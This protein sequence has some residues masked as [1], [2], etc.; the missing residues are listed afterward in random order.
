MKQ[1]IPSPDGIEKWAEWLDSMPKRT[2]LTEEQCR[3]FMAMT[4]MEDYIETDAEAL[5][6]VE[7]KQMNYASMFYNRVKSCHT[8]KVSVAVA[9]FISSLVDRPGLV[10]IYANYLQYK[11]F[12]FGKKKLGMQDMA[13]IMPFGVFSKETL[14]QAWDKQKWYGS[15]GSDNLL[16][17]HEAQKSI[18]L[19]NG[20]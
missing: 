1:K 5:R 7:P 9:L 14:L 12:K 2:P 4:L 19:N 8:Y 3:V 13:L 18:E 15:I 11:A 20:E 10:T 17:Y 16:D 6:M